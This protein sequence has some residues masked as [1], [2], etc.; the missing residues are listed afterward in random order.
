MAATIGVLPF[1]RAATGAVSARRHGGAANCASARCSAVPGRP[2]P[3]TPSGSPSASS[4]SYCW[5]PRRCG[6]APPRDRP[7]LVV[8]ALHGA[9][10]WAVRRGRGGALCGGRHLGAAVHRL[11]ARHGRLALHAPRNDSPSRG[12][13]GDG[14]EHLRRTGCALVAD[15]QPVAA[16]RRR[17]ARRPRPAHAAGR[18]VG[19]H[20]RRAGRA[21]HLRA[22]AAAR[23]GRL[24]RDGAAAHGH[25]HR[26]RRLL[27]WF[28]SA[29]CAV[30]SSRASAGSPP[31][32]A[33][34]AGAAARASCTGAEPRS[35]RRGRS[36][37]PPSHAGS[38]AR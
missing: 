6:P 17:R 18:L 30:P 22:A 3:A 34:P 8:Q 12:A 1:R 25:A 21:A 29:C 35:C 26:A 37:G 7:R 16:G 19:H 2:R 24:R 31:P 5:R 9:G 20:R 27:V 36:R 10:Q 13:R 14:R 38:R 4:C 15:P 32:T 23:Q 33:V 11:A 28:S